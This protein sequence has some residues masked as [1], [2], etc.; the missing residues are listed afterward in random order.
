MTKKRRPAK[1]PQHRRPEPRRHLH[2]VPDR[3]A[4][5]SPDENARDQDPRAEELLS[6]VSEAL[7][8]DTAIH[9]IQLVSTI[10]EVT[11]PR[12]S[13]VDLLGG[14]DSE[15]DTDRISREGLV[16]SF[17]GTPFAETTALLTVMSQML[18]PTD[19]AHAAIAEELAH[20]R[21]PLPLW[22]RDLAAGRV[23][24]AVARM[25][26]SAG[27]GENCVLGARFP[28]GDAFTDVI[29]IDHNLGSAVKGAFLLDVSQEEL[30]AR[31]KAGEF[32]TDEAG[33][34]REWDAAAARA[35]VT[36]AIERARETPGM[37]ED[38]EWPELR[39]ATEWLL[40]LL[41]DGGVAE[42]DREWTQDDLD[43][44][45]AEFLASDEFAAPEG[46]ADD[47]DDGT[48]LDLDLILQFGA[49]ANVGGPLRWSPIVAEIFLLD[50]MPNVVPVGYEEVE[51]VPTLLADFVRFVHRREGVDQ[52]LTDE[53]LLA[54]GTMVPAF[55]EAMRATD[56]FGD[57]DDELEAKAF[58]LDRLADAVGGRTRLSGLDTEPL[59]DE[60]F[61][62]DGIPED[63][64]E[65]VGEYLALLDQVADQH[66]DVEHRTAMRRFLARAAAADPG[67]FRRRSL[68]ARGAAAIGWAVI[69]AN[70]TAGT[71]KQGPTVE[72]AVGWFGVTGAVSQRAEVFLNAIDAPMEFAWP[73]LP[74]GSADLLVSARR[75]RIIAERDRLQ[76]A[77]G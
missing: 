38:Q 9:L 58:L 24:V 55:G 32:G 62:W 48:I 72:E 22:L 63:I 40:S 73:T 35:T 10:I 49:S 18:P 17:I 68:V 15:S 41:P 71:F 70:E 61:T 50:W 14:G 13:S 27:D 69:R 51:E 74:L 64:R 66:L 77:T 26:E 37:I 67:I 8:A 45:K 52:D 53:V 3:A 75:A 25:T 33:Y 30:L 20:R 59:P 57:L 46:F 43:A 31:V 34:V 12:G 76:D 39:P 21:H 6:G 29:F 56:P 2:A 16:D 28:S 54:I 5:E 4:H 1:R 19:S 11:D 60:D 42:A 23:E 65:R 44:L 47:E 7:R 36:A